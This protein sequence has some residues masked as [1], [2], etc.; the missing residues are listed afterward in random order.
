MWLEWLMKRGHGIRRFTLINFNIH[1]MGIKEPRGEYI[2]KP[3]AWTPAAWGT[4]SAAYR[5]LRSEYWPK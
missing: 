4:K 2:Y 5:N 1:R 3:Q